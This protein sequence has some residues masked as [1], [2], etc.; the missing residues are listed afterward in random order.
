MVDDARAHVA[1]CSQLPFMKYVITDNHKVA[2][3]DNSGF[4]AD[5]GEALFGQVTGAGYMRIENGRVKVFGNS[6]GYGIT[7]KDSDAEIIE[8]H[9]DIEQGNW[10]CGKCDQEANGIKGE[11]IPEHSRHCAKRS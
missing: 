1:L 10:Q 9:L 7:A 6:V 8:K 3:I 11:A 5:L 4:H 2:L